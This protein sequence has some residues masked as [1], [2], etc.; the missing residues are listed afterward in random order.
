MKDR[1][2]A[3]FGED[4]V[5]ILHHRAP[6][7]EFERH[8]DGENYDTARDQAKKRVDDTKQF[9]RPIK[10]LTPYQLLKLMF[11]CRYFEIGLT[12]IK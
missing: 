6:L 10:V 3:I 9:Y 4:Q 12:G 11:G 7:Q 5:G 2:S 8:F 1:L